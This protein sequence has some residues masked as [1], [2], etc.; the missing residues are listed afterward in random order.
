MQPA[1]SADVSVG[2]CPPARRAGHRQEHRV[3]LIG[4]RPTGERWAIAALVT[5]AA[6]ATPTAAHAAGTAVGA[7]TVTSS[8]SLPAIGSPATIRFT[9]DLAGTTPPAKF[10][11]EINGRTKSVRA[12]GGTGSVQY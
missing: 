3:S 1:V 2:E 7:T 5:L 6:I 12:T 11:Y 10:V 8:T 9:A 4:A